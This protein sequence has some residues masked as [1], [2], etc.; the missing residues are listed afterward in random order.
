MDAKL[1]A[2]TCSSSQ[3]IPLLLKREGFTKRMEN[4][5]EK[6]YFPLT[7]ISYLVAK[8]TRGCKHTDNENIP[9]LRTEHKR[10]LDNMLQMSNVIDMLAAMHS[11]VTMTNKTRNR[12]R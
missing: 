6:E 9:S 12:K 1:Y 7:G 10:R 2:Q 3:S 8:V 4:R 11:N 5:N